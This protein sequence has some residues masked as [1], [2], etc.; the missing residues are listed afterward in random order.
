[1]NFGIIPRRDIVIAIWH[2]GE[3]GIIR[4][5]I[6]LDSITMQV[7]KESRRWAISIDYE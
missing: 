7:A 3:Y 2:D 6:Y 1:M 4:I 5:R